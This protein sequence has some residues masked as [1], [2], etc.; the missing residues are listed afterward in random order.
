MLNL[1]PNSTY[2]VLL[3]WEKM[4]YSVATKFE[5]GSKEEVKQKN[6][7]Q[8]ESN[9]GDGRDRVFDFRRVRELRTQREGRRKE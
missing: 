7:N 5:G 1:G 9:F 3:F 6:E 8:E 2:H 4:W